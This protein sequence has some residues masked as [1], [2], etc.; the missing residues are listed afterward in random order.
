MTEFSLWVVVVVVVVVFEGV[1]G[2]CEEGTRGEVGLG[3]T[4]LV[5]I[6]V[7]ALTSGLR[8]LTLAISPLGSKSSANFLR[9]EGLS[10]ELVPIAVRSW[11]QRKPIRGSF[12]SKP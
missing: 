10:F 7:S 5:E 9:V 1:S 12:S 4:F 11:V 6:R 3:G 8:V 2:V